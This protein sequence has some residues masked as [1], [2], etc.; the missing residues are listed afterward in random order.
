[1]ATV[2]L[3]ITPVQGYPGNYTINVSGSGFEPYKEV[4]W[5]LKG[6]DTFFDDN[7][8][9]P[10]GGGPVREDGTFAFQDSAI[11]GNLN[12]DWGGDEIYADVY[13]ASFGEDHFKSN[14]VKGDF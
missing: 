2:E 14:T 7:I 10:R 1:M 13:Y 6:E 11:G 3:S 12:E 5:Q 8:I 9:A 4:L